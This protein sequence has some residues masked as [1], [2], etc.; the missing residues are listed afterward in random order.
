MSL[1]SVIIPGSITVLGNQAFEEC[2]N[3][4]DITIMDGVKTIGPGSFSMCKNLKNINFPDSLIEIGSNAFQWCMKLASITILKNVI[5]ITENPFIRCKMININVS[6]DN[7]NYSSRDGVLYNKDK[8]RI[9]T[10]PSGI[11]GNF[12]LLSSV[13]N[14]EKSAF[15]W[16]TGLRSLMIPDSVTY[17]E[18]AAFEYMGNKQTICVNKKQSEKWHKF[19]KGGCGANIVY[20]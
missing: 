18:W 6:E 9:I 16:C 4:T 15:S 17:V 14:I 11:K 8:T 19:W 1:T 10:V 13:R 3:L 2:K 12:E 20:R 5:K 7:P